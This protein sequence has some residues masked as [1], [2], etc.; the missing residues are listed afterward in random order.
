MI[1]P[2]K[3][4]IMGKIHMPVIEGENIELH[5][6]QLQMLSMCGS[7]VVDGEDIVRVEPPADQEK[8]NEL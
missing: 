3:N 8:P 5:N 1:D 4:I 6:L 2:I 7:I